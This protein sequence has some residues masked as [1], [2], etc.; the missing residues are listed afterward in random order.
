MKLNKKQ[1]EIIH[2]DILDKAQYL[3]QNA[4]PI[5]QETGLL[6]QTIKPRQQILDEIEKQ[7]GTNTET[8]KN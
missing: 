2:A 5:E 7:L 1:L 6:D 3:I 4:T 8:N